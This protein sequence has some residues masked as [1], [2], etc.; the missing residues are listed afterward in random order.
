[1][2]N[3]VTA[4]SRVRAPGAVACPNTRGSSS[5]HA[6]PPGP[7]ATSA[8][9]A[10][11]WHSLRT[12]DGGASDASAVS[13]PVLTAACASPGRRDH[14]S[15]PPDGPSNRRRSITAAMPRRPSSVS[16]ASD[17]TSCTATCAQEE[18]RVAA[19]RG[20]ERWRGQDSR[21]ALQTG[22]RQ[23]ATQPEDNATP[24][25]WSRHVSQPG[26]SA[27]FVGRHETGQP[28]LRTTLARAPWHAQPID[29]TST[30]FQAARK[31]V[32][33][34]A[35]CTGAPRESARPQSRD[36]RA[37]PAAHCTRHAGPRTWGALL[38]TAAL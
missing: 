24:R 4:V 38:A 28:V 27:C 35:A 2:P 22:G 16:L 14:M 6:D 29:N 13:R 7:A 3:R 12:T 26:A 20:R 8:T 9:S 11:A 33:V 23:P 30:C 1:M 34:G 5:G 25:P 15:L 19:R 10:I 37:F 18:W 17:C 32:E 31:L 36:P 21:A